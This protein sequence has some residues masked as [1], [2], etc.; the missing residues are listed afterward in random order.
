MEIVD[1]GGEKPRLP[2]EGSVELRRVQR[3]QR[4]QRSARVA[5]SKPRKTRF[6][7]GLVPEL[8]EARNAIVPLDGF[9]VLAQTVIR[10]SQPEDGKLM[11]SREVLLAGG[12][13][14][15]HPLKG[16]DR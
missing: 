10:A 9:G 4:A 7:K 8:R 16:F 5:I 6:E 11:G 13:E 3:L 12:G 1:R 15:Q 2:L 14:A